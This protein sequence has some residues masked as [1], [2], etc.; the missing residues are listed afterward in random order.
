M[1]LPRSRLTVRRA[2]AVVAAAVVVLAWLALPYGASRYRG[3]GAITDRGFWS[4]PRYRISLPPMDLKADRPHLYKLRGTPPVPLTLVL[5]VVGPRPLEEKDLDALS[6]VG[7]RV[8]VTI[9]DDHGK[10]VVSA[11]GPLNEW[12][13]TRGNQYAAFWHRDWVAR[14][15]RQGTTYTLTVSAGGGSATPPL[16]IA[17][18]LEGGGNELP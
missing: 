13:L 3:D 7:T 8:S 18:T 14:R 16:E 4:Y 10:A 5:E 6:S 1:L 9:T 17:P 15:L 2:L 12:V 11:S